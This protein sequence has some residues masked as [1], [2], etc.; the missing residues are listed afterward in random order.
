MPIPSIPS[1]CPGTPRIDT[2]KKGEYL[3]RIH[4]ANYEGNQFNPNPTTNHLKG[5][6]FDTT[7]LGTA[8]FYAGEDLET[9]VAEVLMRDLPADISNRIVPFGKVKNRRISK[10]MLERD[11]EIVS[12]FNGG[13]FEL[14]LDPYFTKCDAY[15]YE[16]TR[17]WG[18][19]IRIWAEDKHKFKAAGFKWRS[20]RH[21]GKFSFVLYS[22]SAS[23]IDFCVDSKIP[24]DSGSGLDQI[25]DILARQY[26]A[27]G[28]P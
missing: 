14:G 18:K 2:L 13:L 11:L 22:P 23:L 17:E 7:E 27:L 9:A 5:G 12:L 4:L 10:L 26:V 6:R 16:H 25:K 20:R 15:E 1:D 8:F 19:M 24:A 21:E 28:S 3:Y